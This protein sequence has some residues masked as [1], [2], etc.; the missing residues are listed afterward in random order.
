MGEG[1]LDQVHRDLAELE[2][3]GCSYVVLDTYHDDVEAVRHA[4]PSWRMLSVLAEKVVDL[5]NQTVR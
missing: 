3:L 5:V 4:E 1:S 2:A